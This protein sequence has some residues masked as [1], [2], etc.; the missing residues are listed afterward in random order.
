[1]VKTT[2]TD[3]F[4]K[5]KNVWVYLGKMQSVSY[6]TKWGV[7]S[8]QSAAFA[9]T[10]YKKG[11]YFDYILR[12]SMYESYKAQKG[13]TPFTDEQVDKAHL[14]KGGAGQWLRNLIKVFAS[15]QAEDEVGNTSTVSIDSGAGTA[16]KPSGNEPWHDT[17]T[18]LPGDALCIPGTPTG[19]SYD[20]DNPLA[21]QIRQ[22]D[23]N[24]LL[25]HLP[26]VTPHPP[27]YRYGEKVPR[28]N[29]EQ[30]EAGA[31]LTTDKNGKVVN[32][33]EYEN[34]PTSS[35]G[36]SASDDDSDTQASKKSKK[37]K[38]KHE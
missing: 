6:K 37:Q 26:P 23:S 27:H 4:G 2:R 32:R 38:G 29:R 30:L 16:N 7:A 36:D 8:G 20:V 34:R 17:E 3:E 13:Y 11:S 28:Y 1:M 24:F 35:D 22:C 15:P 19:G 21:S 31:H 25:T 18:Q 12:E 5:V 33:Y 14:G 10:V 9:V